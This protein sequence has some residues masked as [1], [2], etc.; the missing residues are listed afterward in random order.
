MGWAFCCSTPAGRPSRPDA[1]PG[2]QTAFG[3]L[4]TDALA[5]PL[6]SVLAMGFN[7]YVVTA[8]Q[9]I[10]D[11]YAAL[12]AGRSIAGAVAYARR[13]Q[14]NRSGSGAM[15]AFD[16]V[17]P[18]LYD[19]GTPAIAG[20][21]EEIPAAPVTTS[22]TTPGGGRVVHSGWCSWAQGRRQALFGRDGVLLRLER[23]FRQPALV[24]RVLGWP[25]GRAPLPPSSHDGGAPRVV[26]PASR[27]WLTSR[28]AARSVSSPGWW[29]TAGRDIGNGGSSLVLDE[30][31]P[32]R[33][34]PWPTRGS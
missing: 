23:A 26:P 5:A 28:D 18:V 7:V 34:G 31:R 10:A 21:H 25:G 29:P 30:P 19:S 1:A 33:H 17:V 11:V 16:W 3:S 27:Q 2:A 20:W 9:L 13:E 12:G 4:A 32:P 14:A 15:E 22:T 6:G 8:A 24:E